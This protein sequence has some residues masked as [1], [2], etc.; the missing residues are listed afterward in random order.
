VDS[1][2][3]LGRYGRRSIQN[4]DTG[5]RRMERGVSLP[6]SNPLGGSNFIESHLRGRLLAPNR[7]RLASPPTLSSGYEVN[8]F[9]YYYA[10]RFNPAYLPGLCHW[11]IDSGSKGQV[12]G[13]IGFSLSEST[14]RLVKDCSDLMSLI[15]LLW[16]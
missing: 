7:A 10:V 11:Q 14:I 9:T 1:S 8:L 16:R 5:I 12:L 13:A 2:F 6:S 4:A 15:G 3:F